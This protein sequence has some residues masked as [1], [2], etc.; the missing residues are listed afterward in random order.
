LII[1]NNHH[2]NGLLLW[3]AKG[4]TI[5]FTDKYWLDFEKK[6]FDKAIEFFNQNKKKE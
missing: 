3:D 5:Y 4:S 6:D 1:M 2:Y